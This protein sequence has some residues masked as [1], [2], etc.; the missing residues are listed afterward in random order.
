[1]G[2]SFVLKERINYLCELR[3]I[4]RKDL[5]EGLVTLTHFSNILAGRYPLPDDLAVAL[6]TRLEVAPEYLRD[7]GDCSDEVVVFAE[8]MVEQ[9]L[10]NGYNS[11]NI[12][13]LPYVHNAVLVELTAHLVRATTAVIYPEIV[14]SQEEQQYLLLHI[15]QSEI[16]ELP[17]ALQKA[18]LS[19]RLYV[20]RRDRLQNEVLTY[21]RQLQKMTF[22]S[23]YVW[24]H[25]LEVEVEALL[26]GGYAEA[27]QDLLKRAIGRCYFEGL[28]YHLTQL[29]V[30]YSIG[31]VNMQSWQKALYYLEKAKEQLEFTGEHA[32]A[33]SHII[34]NNSIQIR[35]KAGEYDA[36]M[37]E[38]EALEVFL[39]Q[40]DNATAFDGQMLLARCELA[41]KMGNFEQ[42]AALLDSTDVAA[43]TI[44][45]QMAAAF[46][47]SQ[48]AY[49]QGDEAAFL[50][51][52][53][54][55]RLYFEQFFNRDRL[56]I[57]YS[58]LASLAK[59]SRQYKQSS[60]YF[61]YLCQILQ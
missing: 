56:I 58:Q 40:T 16:D 55:C 21:C 4:E 3:G 54:Q 20:A 53:E 42:M 34:A 30:M 46:Y 31:F 48:L 29:Y 49:E 44:E 51:A 13:D 57:L 6:A 25:L 61:E 24:I 19:Y 15:A 11:A 43:M 33:Y 5:V 2:R 23:P 28:Y 17:D 10:L 32:V 8:Q 35:L 9:L 50:I 45:Q 52:A 47:R 27:A 36:A 59:E 22:A 41:F 18:V 12:D 39:K 7:A 38:I 37:Q 14:V 1:M 60:E 26:Y